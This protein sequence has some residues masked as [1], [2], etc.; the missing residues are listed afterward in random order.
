MMKV[1]AKMILK[2]LSSWQKVRRIS[3]IFL[4][5]PD[6]LLK[7][8]SS[9]TMH[10]IS[11]PTMKLSRVQDQKCANVKIRGWKYASLCF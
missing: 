9:N 6:L 11:K 4:E 3:A 7:M 8:T 10:K 1:C 2:N 5:E